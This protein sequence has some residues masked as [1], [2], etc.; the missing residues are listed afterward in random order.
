M[1]VINS[2]VDQSR[3][4]V[5]A[6]NRVRTRVCIRTCTIIIARKRV[7]SRDTSRIHMWLMVCIR[8]GGASRN[9]DRNCMCVGL[10]VV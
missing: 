3:A 6:C 5:I 2:G 7:R 1:R 4:S 8:S 10:L 9:H